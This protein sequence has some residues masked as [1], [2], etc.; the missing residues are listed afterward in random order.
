MATNHE[1][2]AMPNRR[3]F[4]KTAP[5]AVGAAMVGGALPEAPAE[6]LFALPKDSEGNYTL[7]PLPYPYDAL[8]PHIDAET[9]R[10]HHDL[11][12]AG[13]VK[14]FNE[15][16]AALKRCLET[17][18]QA[19]AAYAAQK[20]AFHGSGHVLHSIFWTNM[21]PRGG[22]E[23]RGSLAKRIAAEFNSF[24][25]FKSQFLSVANAVEGSGWGVLAYHPALKR[26]LILQ[27]EKHQ[28][29][30]VWG[31]VPLL[32]V[33]VWE[34]AYYLRYQNRRGD[35]LKAFFNV[36]NWENVAARLEAAEKA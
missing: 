12:H 18:D 19:G 29:L 30:T 4:L 9:M 25:A 32:V 13:Y 14:G 2:K 7:P 34:H 16:L 6:D 17:G 11:H 22:G 26:I 10:L 36:I 23:P 33:D 1:G 3:Q 8:E 15:A 28:N 35:Y 24:E 20:A 31:V 5:A 27:A 21:S